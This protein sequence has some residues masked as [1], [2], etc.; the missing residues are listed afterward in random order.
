[1][2]IIESIILGIVQGLTEFLPISSTGHLTLA[3]KLMGVIDPNNPKEWTSF[4][5]VIQLG[6]MVAVI[7]YF[8]KDLF[9]ILQNFVKDNLTQRKIIKVQS[10]E[11]K[12]GW[13]IIVGT[14]PVVVI[15]L[16]F[17]DIIEGVLTKNLYVISGSLILLA[18]ILWIAEKVG[19][20]E[21]TEDKLSWKDS[22]IVGFAQA[23]SLIPGS[24]RSG[25]TITAGIFLGLTRETAARFS[26]L[27]SI[28]AVFASGMLQFYQALE[29]ITPGSLITLTI[30]TLI[31]GISGYLAIEFLLRF[32]KKNTTF[33]FILY[34]IVIG[35]IIILLLNLGIILP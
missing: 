27:L 14:L 11:S 7:I 16:L 26:F 31:S 20:F 34:R 1:M 21:R 30:A 17:K 28:P 25:T 29:F 5:A 9:S 22:I 8:W 18:L 32:L 24:S 19:K 33:V 2:S 23:L 35:A 15:G 10:R 12:L 3:G 13:F 6:T 4:M